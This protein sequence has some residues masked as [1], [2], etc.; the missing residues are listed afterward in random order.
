MGNYHLLLLVIL[1]LINGMLEG[2][3]KEVPAAGSDARS[4]MDIIVQSNKES[5]VLDSLIE[6][7][8]R[9]KPGHREKRNAIRITQWKWKDNKIPYVIDKTGISDYGYHL[10]LT[11][12]DEYNKV[13]SCVKWVPRT[14]DND[15]VKIKD[16]YGCHSSIGRDGGPQDLVLGST[17]Y[18]KGVIMHE[19]NHAVGFFH[20]QARYDRDKYVRVKWENIVDGKVDD[21]KKQMPNIMDTFDSPYDYGSIMHYGPKTFSKNGETVLEALYDD[22]KT[23][24]QRVGFSDADI[25][26][27]EKLYDCKPGK[28]P[29]PVWM[30]LE[31][32]TEA[33]PSTI[34]STTKLSSPLTSIHTTQ[35]KPS[36]SSTSPMPSSLTTASRV[37]IVT[38]QKSSTLSTGS[39]DTL[40][41]TSTHTIKPTTPLIPSKSTPTTQSLTTSSMTSRHTLKPATK[42]TTS[43]PVISTRQPCE[44]EKN[45]PNGI[46]GKVHNFQAV[47]IENTLRVFWEPPCTSVPLQG[48][49]LSYINGQSQSVVRIH[50]DRRTHYIYTASHPG[51]RYQMTITALSQYGRGQVS[52]TISTYSACG[53]DIVLTENGTVNAIKSP[54]FEK[55]VYEPDVACQWNIEAPEGQ[56]L[57]ISFE[58]LNLAG[59]G[60]CDQDFL[61]INDKRYCNAV[62]SL[63]YIKTNGNKAKIVFLSQ[64]GVSNKQGGFN[65]SVAAVDYKPQAPVVINKPGFIAL[66]WSPPE[67]VQG[68]DFRYVFKYRL[69]PDIQQEVIQLSPTLH[70][71]GFPTVQHLGRQYEVQLSTI[72]G[73]KE[74]S[75]HTLI[76]RSV[77]GRNITVTSNGELHNPPS[78]GSYEPDVVCNWRLVPTGGKKLLLG[79]S[80][81]DLEVTPNCVNDHVDVSG[82]GRFCS[83]SQVTRSLTTSSET[84]VQFKSDQ[85]GERRGF[86]IQYQLTGIWSLSIFVIDGQHVIYVSEGI[87][88]KVRALPFVAQ[89]CDHPRSPT[90]IQRGQVIG[91]LSSLKRCGGPVLGS[92]RQSAILKNALEQGGTLVRIETNVLAKLQLDNNGI[93]TLDRKRS[94]T[95]IP[96]FVTA[97][98]AN[99]FEEIQG[100]IQM[101][102]EKVLTRYENVKFIIYDLGL[103]HRQAALIKKYCK[104]DFRVFPFHEYPEFFKVIPNMAW[105]PVIIQMV[106]MEYDFVTWMDASI[107][108]FGTSL[109]QLFIDTRK[110]EIKILRGFGLIVRQTHLNTFNALGEEPCLYHRPELQT[111]WIIISRTNF[112]L[113]AIMRP[114]VS[115]ALQFGCMAQENTMS[116]KKCSARNPANFL[117]HR[118]D[119]SP[120]SIIL[121]RLFH[122]RL[123]QIYIRMGNKG[124]ILR[125]DISNYLE[126]IDK[127]WHKYTYK[128]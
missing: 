118:F 125:G 80:D 58:T 11:A 42:I 72:I 17:C 53:H 36:A 96:V 75:S 95:K 16:G 22:H 71:F 79:F 37:P 93:E 116:H 47:V 89:A 40:S 70:Q 97:A 27:I 92:C 105:K 104:C 51:S 44:E 38:S 21:F 64:P 62:P 114:W 1:Y 67:D 20:E 109:D 9:P 74:G 73:N 26:K 121:T 63:G 123:D 127:K 49:E 86:L 33:V 102:H 41:K 99:H 31:Q 48:Y 4:L 82:L 68:L 43:T 98:S 115:C 110:T 35:S 88:N 81:L 19:L 85:S 15:Y 124:A 94:N 50:P 25:W 120:L 91:T 122:D 24:G 113:S 57:K 12:I 101:I 13:Q 34:T 117:C 107:R 52:N 106:L 45:L 56:R 3:A 108:L 76:V 83:M 10:I 5:G 87:R 78:L 55:E 7:D 59:T 46:P 77:C 54:Y 30:Q 32:T 103:Q 28:S 14:T 39:P 18:Y 60:G 128:V 29:L 112:T 84:T 111:T 8:I 126:M 90:D 61:L 100:L 119:Q 2:E 6:G 69:L 66:S 65:I 23:M